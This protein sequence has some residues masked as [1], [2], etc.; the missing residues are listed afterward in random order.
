MSTKKQIQER[1][2]YWEDKKDDFYI[3]LQ[4]WLNHEKKTLTITADILY[5]EYVSTGIEMFELSEYKYGKDL[6]QWFENNL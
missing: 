4:N 3:L 5:N 2:Q 6:Q 1:K